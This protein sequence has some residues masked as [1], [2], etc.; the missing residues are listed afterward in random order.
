M[1]TNTH[2]GE[3]ILDVLAEGPVDWYWPWLAL[4]LVSFAIPDE[5]APSPL[6]AIGLGMVTLAALWQIAS[7]AR[8]K[9]RK[10]KAIRARR[11]H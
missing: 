1:S 6:L 2:N 8:G 9:Y 5:G 7:E 4:L 3:G 11:R 10:I